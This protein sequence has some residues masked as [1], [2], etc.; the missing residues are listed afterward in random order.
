MAFD[1]DRVVW[2]AGNLTKPP[3]FRTYDDGNEVVYLSLAIDHQGK[4]TEFLDVQTRGFNKEYIKVQDFDAGD[5]V[6]VGGTLATRTKTTG[7]QVPVLRI[8]VITKETS[9]SYKPL[10]WRCLDKTRQTQPGQDG[11]AV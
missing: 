6:I 7:Q 11:D 5:F 1:G 3:I 8:S 2:K 4:S 9:F 10:D